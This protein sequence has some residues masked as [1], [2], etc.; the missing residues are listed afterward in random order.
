M[1]T[2]KL[3]NLDKLDFSEVFL[4][5]SSLIEKGTLLLKRNV[6]IKQYAPEV[7]KA[8]RALDEIEN[9]DLIASL[10][11]S[12]NISSI[13]K[14]GEGAGASGSFF[15]FTSD[16][17]F[18]MKTMSIKEINHLLRVLPQYYEHVDSFKHSFIAKIYGIFTVRID[19]FEP[20]HVM[21]MQNTMPE[22]PES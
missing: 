2:Q 21:I 14:S 17:R 3:T 12:K 22:V 4:D 9:K 11:P 16:K 20:I 15:F 5:G 13:Q 6:V 7:F 18:T 10:D 19:K 1:E 8:I